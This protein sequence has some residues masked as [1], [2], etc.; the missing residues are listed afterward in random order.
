[1]GCCGKGRSALRTTNR[2]APAERGPARATAQPGGARVA[3]AYAGRTSMLVQGPVTGQLYRFSGQ[4]STV[5]VDA[6][7][8]D[9]IARI[10]QLGGAGGP[11]RRK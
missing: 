3:L 10:P 1:M 7:D 8:A 4:G 2:P 5:Y 11:I 9:S 6:R